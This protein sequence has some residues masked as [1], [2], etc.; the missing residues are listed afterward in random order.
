MPGG[1]PGGNRAL[2]N[3]LGVIGHH[4]A[5]GHFIDATEPMASRASS[6][7]RVGRER[8]GIEMRL[9][10]GISAGPRVQH[11]HQV[12]QRRDAANRGARGWRTALLLQRHGRRQSLDFVDLGNGHLMKQTPRIRGNGFEIPS[13]R[14][15]VEG[16]ECQ[17]RFSR[18]GHAG[19]HNQG[20]PGNIEI[21]ALQIVFAGPAHA[22][23]PRRRDIRRISR[24]RFAEF[25]H[26]HDPVAGEPP[27]PGRVPK[28]AGI[29]TAT[30]RALG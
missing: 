10:A 15:R 11:T 28:A 3:A 22:D 25:R 18:A 2:A 23:Q 9:G 4:G 21:D 5:F 17:R 13:L 14:F 27:E 19:K 1:R 26:L 30:T 8:L 29:E 20:I 24:T 7:G 16:A 6:R 12:G